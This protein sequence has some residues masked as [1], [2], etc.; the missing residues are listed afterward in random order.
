MYIFGWKDLR[1]ENI[2]ET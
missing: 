1:E 2:R